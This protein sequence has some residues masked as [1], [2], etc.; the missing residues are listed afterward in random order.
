MPEQ[1]ENSVLFSLKELR[2]IEDDRI[3]QEETDARARVEAERKAR[4]DAERKARE[5]VERRHREEEDRIR[6]G[7][8]E[9]GGRERGGQMRVAVGARPPPVRG[10]RALPRT[11]LR[12]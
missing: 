7:E 11:P 1:R 2:R 6:P 9:K 4:E 3:R 12:P 8:P 10:E 5:D